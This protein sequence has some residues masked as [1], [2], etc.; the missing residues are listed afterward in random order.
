MLSH[1]KSCEKYL[2]QAEKTIIKS[3]LFRIEE[4]KLI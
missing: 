1:K 3:E 4:L 2:Q